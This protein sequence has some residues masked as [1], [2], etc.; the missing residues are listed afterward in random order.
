MISIQHCRSQW[1]RCL[2]RRSAAARLLSLW[3]R[4]PPGAWMSV[5]DKC[6]VLSGKRSLR[7]ADPLSRG[8]L[9]TVVR[10][11]VR[12]KILVNE[13]ALAPLGSVTSK[14]KKSAALNT[15]LALQMQCNLL[16]YTV[17]LCGRAH[18]QNSNSSFYAGVII[19]GIFSL[20]R[21]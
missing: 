18:A 2:R 5:C 20:L 21:D 12:S 6:C 15:Q 10:R 17:F 8:V 1:P 14:I 11:C 9:S 3:V 4:I 19:F 7:R 16:H 13:E